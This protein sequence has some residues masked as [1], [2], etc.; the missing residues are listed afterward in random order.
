MIKRPTFPIFETYAIFVTGGKQYQGI[1]GKT[2]AVELIEGEAGDPVIIKEVL[3]RKTDEKG[4]QIGTPYVDGAE[5]TT[6]I[7]KQTKGE[8]LIAYKFKRRK[9][10]HVKKGHRQPI[11]VLR[12]E[13]I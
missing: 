4:I 12:I 8:K 6:S 13:A 3:L 7:V 10:Y 2:V 11:T 5:I 9:K 1:P